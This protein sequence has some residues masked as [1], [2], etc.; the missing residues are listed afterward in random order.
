MNLENAER[1]GENYKNLNIVVPKRAF[2]MKLK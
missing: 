1:K 2:E